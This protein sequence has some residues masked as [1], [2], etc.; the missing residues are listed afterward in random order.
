[1]ATAQGGRW[2]ILERNAQGEVVGT[3]FR[4]PGES[5]RKLCSEGGKRGLILPWPLDPYAGTSQDR[6]VWVCEGA[7]DTGAM[8]GLYVD[9]VGVP[10]AGQC[11]EWL[12]ELLE[13]RHVVIIADADEAGERGAQKIAAALVRTCPSVRIIPPPD[14]AKDARAA[15]LGGAAL[16]AF[17]DLSARAEI[18]TPPTTLVDGAP[19]LVRLSDVKPEVVAWLWF[20]RFALGK[21][22]L[23]AGDPGLGKS[24]L[25]L[26]MAA[27][28]T[29]GRAW[30][31]RTGELREPGGVVLLSAEDGMADTVVPRLLAAGADLN[32]I[33]ALPAVHQVR[34]NGR[35]SARTF[36]LA[37]DLP[38][39]EEA[40]KRVGNC[41]LVIIDPV[42]AYLGE[43]NSHNNAEV[44]GLLAPL[45][46]IAE[47]YGVAMVAVTHLNKSGAGPAIYRAMGSLA[48]TAAAR[49]AWSVSKDRNDPER[50][51][52]LAIKN[53]IGPDAGGLA[54]RLTP[55][56]DGTTA[57]VDWEPDPVRMS[58]DEALAT[59]QGDDNDDGRTERDDAADWLRE[60]LRD[61][62]RLV[63]ELEHEARE[64]G[65]TI[66]TVRRA[67][68]R[69]GV[70]SEK[71]GFG[72]AWQWILPPDSTKSPKDII[73]GDRPPK[74]DHLG[75]DAEESG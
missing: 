5:K 67:K 69:I 37:R 10:M 24:F 63:K 3:T 6:P 73:E 59:E 66:I 27:R 48:F 61:G 14:G 74:G 55:V 20:G 26:D 21:L 56:G 70:K 9:A 1:L 25:T 41:R 22:T 31:D 2:A 47:Q 33:I 38:A 42:T 35:A 4:D 43:A 50:R 16:R 46:A 19:I 32:R 18:Y 49:A 58:A 53:N 17:T 62:P 54:Y 36:N 12:A 30:P 68:S 39:L 57:L 60:V 23:I 75:R 51:L 45:S 13:D 44:R 34:G 28:V 11:G 65:F 72:G 52:L 64:A 71:S 15:V 29:T 40:I 8:L 7:S